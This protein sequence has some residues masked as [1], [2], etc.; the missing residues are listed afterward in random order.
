M[1]KEDQKKM[2]L[3][4]GFKG[5]KTRKSKVQ[6]H[7]PIGVEREYKRMARAY[8]N[9]LGDILKSRMSDIEEAISTRLDA[10]GESQDTL[11]DIFTQMAKEL[12]VRI[13]RYELE[14]KIKNLAV[15]TNN[16]TS[17]EWQRAIHKTLGVDVTKDFFRGSQYATLLDKWTHDNVSLISKL[18]QDTV[19][20]ME[21][22]ISQGWKDGKSTKSIIEDIMHTYDVDKSYAEFLACDQIGKLN[23]DLSRMQQQSVGVKR[24]QWATAKDSAVRDSHRKLHGKVFSWN[25]PPVVDEKTGRRAHPGEDYRCRCVALAYFDKEEFNIPLEAVDWAKVDKETAKIL[26]PTSTASKTTSRRKRR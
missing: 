15:N 6:P 24:Y 21:G 8:M 7:Y 3:A 23:S 18:P 22:I 13:G 10:A 1:N 2:L 16:M 9:I 17:R 20:K 12:N 5:H 4:K 11:H 19:G 14:K 25:D 26:K